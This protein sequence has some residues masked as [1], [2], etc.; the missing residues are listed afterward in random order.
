[1][2]NLPESIL[3]LTTC[4]SS[5]PVDSHFLSLYIKNV[6]IS[7][8]FWL[9]VLISDLRF[10]L[11]RHV[12]CSCDPG[13]SGCLTNVGPANAFA[14]VSLQAEKR[15]KLCKKEQSSLSDTK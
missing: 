2:A 12:C 6:R 11:G 9:H 13:F 7:S 10:E 4:S 1:M 14:V 3:G 5:R 15:M 8:A